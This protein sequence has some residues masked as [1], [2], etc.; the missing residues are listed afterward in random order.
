[1]REPAGLSTHAGNGSVANSSLLGREPNQHLS[2]Q[3][4]ALMV[5]ME[6]FLGLASLIVLSK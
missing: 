4:L 5:P 1:M 2:P 3:S 6:T